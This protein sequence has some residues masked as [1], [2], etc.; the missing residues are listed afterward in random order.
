VSL[1]TLQD[2]LRTSIGKRDAIAARI[3]TLR[4]RAGVL[5]TEIASI[6]TQAEQAEASFA[7]E[8]RAHA[9]GDKSDVASA[10]KVRADAVMQFDERRQALLLVEQAVTSLEADHVRAVQSTARV[11]ERVAVA[12]ARRREKEYRATATAFAQAAA[13][14]HR[15]CFSADHAAFV[16][17]G[18]VGTEPIAHTGWRAARL[19]SDSDPGIGGALDAVGV[20]QDLTPMPGRIA[21]L[22]EIE[23]LVEEDDED[24]AAGGSRGHTERA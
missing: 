13:S 14:Y 1:A 16:A 9:L 4:T 11:A 23:L 18:L 10:R 24:H 8:L 20:A 21:A 7:V 12:I 3:R 2:E 6:E 22:T 19:A 17:S 15:A 5:D